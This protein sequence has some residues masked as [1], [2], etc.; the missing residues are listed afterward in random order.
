MSS[1]AIR[2]KIGQDF[3]HVRSETEDELYSFKK[4]EDSKTEIFQFFGFVHKKH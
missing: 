2:G 3:Q 4:D 1:I